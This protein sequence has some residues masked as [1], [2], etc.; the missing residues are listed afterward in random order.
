MEKMIDPMVF[1]LM[2]CFQSSFINAFGEF[3]ATNDHHAGDAWF[4]ISLCRT[5]EDL[6]YKVLSRLVRAAYK[7]EP[8]GTKK[9]N[10]EFHDYVRSGMN[11]FLGTNFDAEDCCMIYSRFGNGV[12]EEECREF[13]RAGYPV[14]TLRRLTT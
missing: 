12:N 9:K 14:D 2:K 11:R 5:E 13:I 10:D 3:V 1:D 7:T 4:R 8:W 6:R